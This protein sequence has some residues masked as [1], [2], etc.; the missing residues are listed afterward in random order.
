METIM[1]L[2]IK[3]IAIAVA[4]I[5]F[6]YFAEPLQ[7]LKKWLRV[8][9]FKLFNCSICFSFW[10]SIIVLSI[11]SNYSIL[12]IIGLS[13]VTQLLTATLQRYFIQVI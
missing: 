1:Y 8:N 5:Q 10:L 6:A 12:Q 9:R 11:T 2:L 7:L 3:L 4:S 13:F